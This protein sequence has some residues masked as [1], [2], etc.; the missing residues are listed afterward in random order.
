MI[1][2]FGAPTNARY[3]EDYVP[4]HVH[5]FGPIV[6]DEAEVIAFARRYDPQP[7]HIDPE[8]ARLSPYGGLIASGWQTA[9]LMMRLVVEHYLSPVSS[10]GSPGLD[11]LRW[12]LPV[13]PGDALTVRATVTSSRRSQSKP[14]R[15]IV[16]TRFEVVNQRGQVVM[17]STAMNFI[18]VRRAE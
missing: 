9:G 15:G 17:S 7:F 3:F 5:E 13:R 1:D 4:G 2:P 6:V 8:A 10:L 14:D 11:E 16:Q 18:R 12:P